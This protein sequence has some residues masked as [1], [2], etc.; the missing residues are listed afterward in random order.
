MYLHYV[1]PHNTSD[2]MTYIPNFV[3]HSMKSRQIYTVKQQKIYVEKIEN[4]QDLTSQQ[5]SQKN[6]KKSHTNRKLLRVT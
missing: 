2:I 6:K 5:D 3:S 4:P 1:G